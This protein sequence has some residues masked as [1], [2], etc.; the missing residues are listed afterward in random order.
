MVACLHDDGVVC[1]EISLKI[2][3]LLM[4]NTTFR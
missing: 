2:G 3:N 4:V 1:Q